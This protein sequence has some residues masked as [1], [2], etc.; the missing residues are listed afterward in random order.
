MGR[1]TNIESIRALEE[2]IE[3]GDGDIIKLKRGRNSLLNTSTRVPPEI[4]GNIFVWSVAREAVH[5]V[6]GW[7]FRGLHKGS[8]NFL[9]VCHHWFKVAYRTP[10]LWSFW[11]NTLRDWKKRHHRSGGAPL[12]PVLDGSQFCASS[13]SEPE[14]S[15]LDEP[16]QDA[17]RDRAVRDAVRQVHIRGSGRIPLSSVISLLTPDGEDVRHSSVE[18]IDLRLTDSSTLDVSNFFARRRLPKLRYL[19]LCGTL[20]TPSWDHFV[21]H[22]TLLTTL[23]LKI[24]HEASTPPPTTSQLLSTL[25]SNPN[26]QVLILTGSVIP[27]DN[28][29]STF[30]IPLRHLEKL[31]L[32][33]ELRHVFRLLD[34]LSLTGA[35]D[36]LSLTVHNSTVDDVLQISGSYLR[37]YFRH[38]HWLQGRLGIESRH[39]VHMGN[40]FCSI[41]VE[42][43]GEPHSWSPS[44]F[45]RKPLPSVMFKAIPVGGVSPCIL[46]SLSL[47]LIAFTP[48]ERMF[49]FKTDVST[50][51][52]RMENLLVAM[53]NV[54]ILRLSN[55]ELDKG[56]LQPNPDGPRANAKLL[57]SLQS[58]YIRDVRS[59]GGDGWGHLIAYLAH[60]ISGGEAISLGIGGRFHLCPE[61][62]KEIENLVG[63]YGHSDSRT[64]CPSGRCEG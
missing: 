4:I 8:Y 18:S 16:L 44:P 27:E 33:G 25:V 59:G 53:P 34:R 17:L 41:H 56:F 49:R 7:H 3:R 12:D 28:D 24:G 10:G 22:T 58:L 5:S 15:N 45:Q 2:Q 23:S 40:D 36:F 30:Q 52:K 6:Y 19:F 9:L 61:V 48:G 20:K 43:L 46:G 38:D 63:E 57:P 13:P 29:R 64:R 60:Q 42:T 31:R 14:V 21:P 1:E 39:S 32:M 55:V 37:G 51:P 26:L 54:E 50:N 47:K 35:L 62:A 11:G